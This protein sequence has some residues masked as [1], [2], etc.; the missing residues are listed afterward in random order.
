MDRNRQAGRREDAEGEPTAGGRGVDLRASA[1]QHL[2]A[3]AADAEILRRGDQTAME[4]INNFFAPVISSGTF[5][6]LLERNG[7]RAS[8]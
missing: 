7:K 6:P 4:R 8:L 1:G 5:V 3:H 2:E